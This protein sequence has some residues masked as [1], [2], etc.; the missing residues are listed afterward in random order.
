VFDPTL[1]LQAQQLAYDAAIKSPCAGWRAV[2][3]LFRAAV[4]ADPKRAPKSFKAKAIAQELADYEHRSGFAPSLRGTPQS[5]RRSACSTGFP[6]SGADYAWAMPG[7]PPRQ[8]A[9][10][11]CRSDP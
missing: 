7:M 3:E 4:R 11:R 10:P 8:L 6:F 5:V 2:A 1:S 9:C